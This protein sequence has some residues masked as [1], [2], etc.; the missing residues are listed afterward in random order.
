MHVIK[1]ATLTAFWRRH[2]AAEQPL[3]NWFTLMR[4]G[5]FTDFASV[6]AVWGSADYV[7]GLVVFNVGGNNFRLIV[8][9]EYGRGRVYI[10]HVLTHAEYDRNDW[11]RGT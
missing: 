5:T 10:L 4:R 3:R 7:D 8:N 6:R 11:K 1:K 9:I 2:A